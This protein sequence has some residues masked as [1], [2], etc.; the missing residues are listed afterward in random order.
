MVKNHK[1]TER[2]LIEYVNSGEWYINENG[3]IWCFKKRTG[4]KEGGVRLY[5]VKPYRIERVSKEGYLYVRGSIN[6]KRYTAFAHRLVWQHFNGD[7]NDWLTINH[8]DGN[9]ANNKLSN[10]EL[11]TYKEQSKHSREVLGNVIDQYGEKNPSFKLKDSEIIS[12]R[13]LY[14]SKLYTQAEIGKMFGVAHQTISKIVNGDRRNKTGE[15]EKKDYRNCLKS[16][17]DEK[18]KFISKNK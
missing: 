3:E 10:L 12:I 17:R 18:G 7:I 6:G 9:K 8:I 13:E 5:D 1:L 2:L 4:K 11:A 14:K 15:I 16:V